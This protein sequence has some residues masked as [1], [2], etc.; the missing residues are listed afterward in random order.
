MQAQPHDFA[1]GPFADSHN[2]FMSADGAPIDIS[3]LRAEDYN[4]RERERGRRAFVMR[5]LDEQ[6]SMAGFSRTLSDLCEMGESIDVIG[7]MT[8]IVRDGALHV[9]MCGQVVDALGGWPRDAPEPNW[10]NPAPGLSARRRVIDTVL[11]SMCIGQSISVAMIAG[12]RKNTTD[13][14]VKQLMTRML[15]DESVHARFGFWWLKRR[16]PGFSDAEHSW[17]EARL[18]RM[19]ASVERAARPG[20]EQL[21]RPYRQSP[22]GGMSNPER[23]MAFM[24]SLDREIF[25][26][27]AAVGIDA[28]DAWARREDRAVAVA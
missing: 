22:F 20:V 2:R 25:P 26:S 12:A 28:R 23:E 17:V 24:V 6:R 10:V 4:I 21:T 7:T 27:F 19:F 11:G 18:P 16:L 3:A 13:P 14:V 15:A 1:G 5:T 8:R 9:Q